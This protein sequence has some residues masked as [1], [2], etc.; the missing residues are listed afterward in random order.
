MHNLRNKL[1]ELERELKI[2]YLN[3][4]S[5]KENIAINNI[6]ENPKYFY[7]Y[8]K[9]RNKSFTPIG[10]LIIDGKTVSDSECM[11]ESLQQQYL[12]VF[13]GSTVEI[14]EVYPDGHL[15][16]VDL[17]LSE[18]EDAIKGLNNNSSSGPDKVPV[19]LLK[20]CANSLSIPLW[21]IW[22]KSL[23]LGHFPS[24]LRKV[25]ISPIHKGGSR[26]SPI[27]YRPVAISSNISKIVEK[28]ITNR[29]VDYFDSSNNFAPNQH[30][31]RIK[32][33]CLTALLD[34]QN[35]IL[36][37]L[38]K[39]QDVDIIYLDLSKAFDRV[40]HSK[41]LSKLVNAGVGGV[42]LHWIA[43]FLIG[44]HQRVAVN[45][46][47]SSS[48]VV[49]SGV[50]QG[51]V[52]G[53]LL[54]ILFMKDIE[55]VVTHAD[56]ISFADDTKLIS[57]V[58]NPVDRTAMQED[59][60]AVQRWTEANNMK[61]NNDKFVN[62]RFEHNK[63]N[64]AANYNYTTLAGDISRRAQHRDLGII[65][66][67]SGT[68]KCHIAD[69]CNRANMKIAWVL[70]TFNTRDMTPLLTL[71]KSLVL[72]HLEY[73]V[74]LWAPFDSASTLAIEAVQ[75]SFTTKIHGLEQLNYWERLAATGLY[76][77][78]RRK[79]RYLI[80]YT[81]KIIENLVVC[82][83]EDYFRT[84]YSERR[85]RNIVRI[86]PTNGAPLRVKNLR[87]RSLFIMGPRLF[88]SVPRTIRDTTRVG[89]D[90]FKMK[91]DKWLST[92]P[93]EPPIYKNNWSNSLLD[94]SHRW[95]CM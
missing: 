47:C 91:L 75:R 50:P 88:N 90:T 77:L 29:L 16:I 23:A 62:I 60:N 85:G 42:L 27:N 40:D 94:T 11:A 81:W 37:N 48:G 8:A 74:Q 87:C 84:S 22:R 10:P 69:K 35:L 65:I 41:L 79:E 66:E 46:K 21:L 93:D 26:G 64:P 33:S 68:Y 45:G 72:P 57:A 95:H 6:K 92:I 18:I 3:D 25:I 5:F 58:K 12:S 9:H 76:S 13:G 53:P 43:E 59:I 52:L 49:T 80:I 44:R 36:N 71:Y 15:N 86:L 51:S 82:P 1:L 67:D 89:L 24:A 30:G 4:R 20:K 17:Q 55:D 63:S 34:M 14:P 31:F 70:R 32:R 56:L 28:I 78:Q 2:S 38:E 19:C 73:C 39:H 83:S 61:F 54:F 7:S